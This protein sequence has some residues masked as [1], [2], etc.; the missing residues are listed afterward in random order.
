[1]NRYHIY[2]I[3]FILLIVAGQ[4]NASALVTECDDGYVYKIWGDTV[5]QATGDDGMP[6]I[7]GER[8]VARIKR[9][10]DLDDFNQAYIKATLKRSE[11]YLNLY[12]GEKE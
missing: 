9:L 12:T 6:Q 5:V 4:A 1:M 2:A 3:F 8:L 10:K 7:C 11:M